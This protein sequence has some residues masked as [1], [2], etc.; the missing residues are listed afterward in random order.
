MWWIILAMGIIKLF[1]DSWQSWMGELGCEKNSC[2]YWWS[3][4]IVSA[5]LLTVVEKNVFLLITMILSFIMAI[6]VTI[7][8]A[9]GRKLKKIAKRGNAED[10]YVYGVWLTEKGKWCLNKEW[11]EKAAKQGH[12]GAKAKL[13]ELRDNERKKSESVPSK[14]VENTSGSTFANAQLNANKMAT[15]VVTGHSCSDCSNHLFCP[16]DGGYTKPVVNGENICHK[17]R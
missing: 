3:S 10:Q 6:V 12:T 7:V 15:L 9:E 16:Y 2:I 13:K 1:Y 4:L 5:F 8:G 14:S 17:W 11:F